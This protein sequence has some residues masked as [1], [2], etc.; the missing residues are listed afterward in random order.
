MYLK[1]LSCNNY[2]NLSDLELFF[3][4]KV[5]IFIGDNGQGKTNLLEAIY[6]MSLTKSFKTSKINDI[7][8]FA[9]NNFF[10]CANIVKNDFPYQIEV[11]YEKQKKNIKINNNSN[12]KFKDVI[13]LLNAVLFVP[14]DLQ[15]LKGNPKLRRKLLDIELSKIY[16][17]YLVMLSSY[18]NV[19]KQRNSY[20]KLNNIDELVID[21]L[22]VQLAQ[23]GD[24][25]KEYR[26]SFIN[27]LSILVNDFYKTISGVNDEITMSY[28][29]TICKDDLTFYDNL[30]KSLE[31]DIVLQQTNIGIHRDD[32][33]VYINDKDASIYGSQGE[34]RTIILAIK[35][36]LVEYIYQKTQEYPILL[37]D[38]VMSEL[39]INRQ[40][41]LVKY[42]NMKVQTFITTTNIDSL[43]REIIDDAKL[44]LINDGV[45]EEANY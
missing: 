21:S 5:N 37:L 44:Y 40:E 34:Q 38:D 19:L 32:F 42:L 26:L 18:Y 20:L 22:D 28:Q 16:P 31:R 7:I 12:S 24:S 29:C 9:H 4:E 35:L 43:N 45:V 13:G 17:R 6:F 33:V 25:L 39:D 2:R 1:S 11:T 10:V 36:A 23:Y 8:S 14:E 3:N 41:N 15:L 30:K 27:E